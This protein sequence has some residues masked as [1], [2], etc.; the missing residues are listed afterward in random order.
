MDSKT[1]LMTIGA[2][3]ASNEEREENDFYATDQ[4]AVQLLLYKKKI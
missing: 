2:S 4:N 1:N 3:C